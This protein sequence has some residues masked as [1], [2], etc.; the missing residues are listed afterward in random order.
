MNKRLCKTTLSLK[1]VRTTAKRCMSLHF[2]DF[3][4]STEVVYSGLPA[5]C[6]WLLWRWCVSSFTLSLTQWPVT[7]QKILRKWLLL[8]WRFVSVYSSRSAIVSQ[9]ESPLLSPWSRKREAFATWCTS[10]AWTH[11][12][13]SLVWLLQIW[14]SFWFQP[15]LPLS[16]SLSLKRLWYRKM[17]GSF[18][19]HS[20]SLGAP[21]TPS[22]T[23]SRIYSATQTLQSNTYQWFT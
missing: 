19:W 2:I 22:A 4:I 17:F 6:L 9:L 3:N 1:A 20:C 23:C 7:L 10:S 8:C 12:N 15:R 13:T 5:S 14:L 11:S 18:G 16:V 21:W